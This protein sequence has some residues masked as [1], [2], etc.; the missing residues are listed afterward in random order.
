METAQDGGVKTVLLGVETDQ[1]GVETAVPGR[2]RPTGVEIAVPGR[3]SLAGQNR[4]EI[5]LK[6]VKIGSR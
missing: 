3:D 5:G 2:D 1:P 6:Q 4:V